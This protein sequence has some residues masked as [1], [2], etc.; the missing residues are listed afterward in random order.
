MS[1]AN[2]LDRIVEERA[3]ERMM[4]D[5]SYYLDMNQ[6]EQMATLFVD[7]CEV[8]Y[9]LVEKNS[10]YSL[11]RVTLDFG[12]FKRIDYVSINMDKDG[13]KINEVNS[14]YQK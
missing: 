2:A 5:Y 10:N 3:I 14:V 4:Y 13:W 9:E 7:D 12:N 11:A 1:F 6:P 8:S